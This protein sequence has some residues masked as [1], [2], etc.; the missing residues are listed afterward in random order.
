MP[1]YSDILKELRRDRR[2]TQKQM[3]KRLG[4]TQAVYSNYERGVRHMPLPMLSLLADEL[5]T[6]TDYI[7]GRTDVETP[8]PPRKK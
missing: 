8:Y 7:L 6:S 3:G 5:G 2:I 4:I 1:M